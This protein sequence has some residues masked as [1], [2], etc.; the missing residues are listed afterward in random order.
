VLLASWGVPALTKELLAA[1]PR[2]QLVIYA[3]GSVRG[4]VTPDFWRRGILVSS[5]AA[6]NA[7]PTAA[8]AEAV[9]VLALK[10]A[11][12]YLRRKS[13]GHATL[14]DTASSGL[15][16]ATVGIIGLSR[17]GRLVLQ[18]LR[19]HEITRLLHDPTIAAST[20]QAEGAELVDMMELFRR[21]DVVS[22]HAPLLPSTIR[23]V[24][25][26]HLRAMRSGAAF[27]N[28]ARGAIVC[29]QELA[30]ALRDRPDLTA[31]LDVTEC[32]PLALDSPL[33]RLPNVVLTPHIAGARHRELELLAR[34]ACDE[35][36][37]Y[38]CGQPLAHPVAESDL[39]LQA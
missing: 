2:L 4:F 5:A 10:Q 28:T 24:R 23:L 36:D 32:E 6:A 15:H 29:E 3:A 31:F 7:G 35:L 11:W 16:G 27:V 12:F 9:I 37:R 25:G 8:F 34:L 17:V 20:A 13:T 14:Q 22:L 39:A 18:G 21:S 33:R 38:L 1:M 19:R 26:E 30:E